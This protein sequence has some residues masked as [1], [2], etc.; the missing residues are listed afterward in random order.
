M[1][2]RPTPAFASGYQ[3]RPR[4]HAARRAAVAIALRGMAGL[5]RRRA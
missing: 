2:G 1:I 3:C 5:K 4:L